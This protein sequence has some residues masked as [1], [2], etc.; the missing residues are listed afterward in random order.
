MLRPGWEMGDLP[1]GPGVSD[2]HCLKPRLGTASPCLSLLMLI[3]TI[4]SPWRC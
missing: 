4:P 1:W 3:L 2:R